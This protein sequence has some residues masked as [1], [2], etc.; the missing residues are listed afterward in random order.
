MQ[1]IV[2]RFEAFLLT[3]QRVASNTL[4]AY[5]TDLK[6]FLTY[7]EQRSIALPDARKEDLKDF[8]R[9]LK[10]TLQTNARTMSRKISTLKAFYKYMHKE[11]GWENLGL[12]LSFPKLDKRLPHFLTEDQIE[13]LFK[14]AHNDSSLLGQRNHMLLELLYASGMRISELV[15]LSINDIQWERYIIKI[16]GKGGKERLIPLPETTITHL[17]TY[18]TEIR[19]ACIDQRP[20]TILFPVIYG[21]VIKPLTRQACWHILKQMCIKASLPESISLHQL[22]HSLAT[23]LLKKGAHLRSIQLLLGH[24]QLS[25]VQIYTHVQDERSKEVYKKKHPRF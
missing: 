24:E 22:R 19:P 4:H 9:Y 1:E 12:N 25:T 23:H 16:S 5:S 3:E 13:L 7:L 2:T 8:L 15:G 18:I 21:K 10:E 17:K 6:Q 14:T 20:T 11:S